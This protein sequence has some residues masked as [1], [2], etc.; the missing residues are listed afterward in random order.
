MS[1]GFREHSFLHEKAGRL[2]AGDFA[3][4]INPD[5]H[6]ARLVIV[7]ML[8][9][10]IILSRTICMW[11]EGPQ[12][13]FQETR[14]RYDARNVMA[15]VWM[16]NIYDSLPDM[17]RPYIDWPL[18][19]SKYMKTTFKAD[20]SFWKPIS[21]DDSLSLEK[22]RLDGTEAKIESILQC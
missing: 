11:E 9:L 12:I 22:L 16:E 21:T 14:H 1:L 17:Y 20:T 6:V 8:L 4:F 3:E 13:A 19:F 10:D 2:S 15:I 18:G 7:H 5:N